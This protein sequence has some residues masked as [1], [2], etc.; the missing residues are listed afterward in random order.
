MRIVVAASAA[1][2][3]PV[4][5][6]FAAMNSRDPS[7]ALAR[8]QRDLRTGPVMPVPT[9][10]REFG[11]DPAPLLARAGIAPQL[12][13]GAEN[14]IA[15][16]AVGQLLDDCVRV[17]GCAHFGLLTGQRFE[18][19][20]LGALGVLVRHCASV[21]AALRSLVLYLHLNDRGGVP[22]LLNLGTTRVALGYAI[23][24]PGMPGKT[25]FDD[26]TI[27]ITF[28]LLRQL[29]GAGWRPTEV[30]FAHR[31][32]ADAEPYRQLFGARVR[33]DAEL[34]AVT[35]PAYWLKHAIAGAD[36][37]AHAVL[38]AALRK[39]AAREAS[40]LGERVRRA[41]HSLA[42]VAGPALAPEVAQL[43][44][45]HERQLRRL[46]TLESTTFR[47]L[48]HEARREVAQHLLRDTRLPLP[49]IAAAL[50]YA[51]AAGLSRAFKQW[52]GVAPGAW[53]AANAAAVGQLQG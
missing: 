7:E 32:P 40:P 28:L 11:I 5:K 4:P 18:A 48:A 46:L 9:L 47:Q 44:A 39:A 43:F 23:V 19:A 49:D 42:Y 1:A 17:T 29:C 15:F 10:L 6:A 35:F 12:L 3:H 53:R 8:P 2:S 26:A 37:A 21:G 30:M 25:Q 50:H 51:D 41:L 20:T 52:T 27:A 34:S 22:V 36:P 45:L 24:E 14:R 16:A 33:F 38:E 13:E 31:P